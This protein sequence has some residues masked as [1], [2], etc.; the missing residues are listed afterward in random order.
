M[1]LLRRRMATPNPACEMRSWGRLQTR[2]SHDKGRPWWVRVGVV[3]PPRPVSSKTS[4]CVTTKKCTP[5]KPHKLT[6]KRRPA[7][8]LS[9]EFGREKG[10]CC[11]SVGVFLKM[12]GKKSETGRGR[13]R[14]NALPSTTN[15]CPLLLAVFASGPFP[16]PSCRPATAGKGAPSFDA[17]ARIDRLI[18]ETRE[19]RRPGEISPS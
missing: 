9:I 4:P 5:A 19:E 10:G 15:G 17:A 13:G 12:G 18:Q 8:A 11:T 2:G 3:R 7:G 16:F 14:K 6:S 1:L